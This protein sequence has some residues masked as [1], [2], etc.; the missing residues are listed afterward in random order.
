MVSELDAW[1]VRA[2]CCADRVNAHLGAL[3]RCTSNDEEVEPPRYA[4]GRGLACRRSATPYD[5]ASLPPSSHDADEGASAMPRVLVAAE[6]SHT[7]R[8]EWCSV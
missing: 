8:V 5:A 7:V 1:C 6:D 3:C 2:R 4:Y